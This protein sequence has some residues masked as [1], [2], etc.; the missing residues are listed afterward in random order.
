M[1]DNCG[2]TALAVTYMIKIY[3]PNGLLVAR[4]VELS[5]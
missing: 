3:H 4:N 1:R 2:M 5:G